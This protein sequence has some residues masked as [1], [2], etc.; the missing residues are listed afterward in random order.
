MSDKKATRIQQ[1]EQFKM[2][3]KAKIDTH[4][5]RKETYKVNKNKAYTFL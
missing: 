3:Y 4:V 2:L 5:K 1:D